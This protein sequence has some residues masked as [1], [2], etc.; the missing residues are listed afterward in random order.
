MVMSGRVVVVSGGAVV[1]SGRAVVVS[2][3][4]ASRHRQHS[5]FSN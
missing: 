2:G 3:G 4:A 5:D 1:M